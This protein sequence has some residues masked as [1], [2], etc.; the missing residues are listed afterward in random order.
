MSEHVFSKAD[1]I[2]RL[3]FC[4]KKTLGEI[5]NK[6]I[7]K[8]LQKF[9]HQ[10]GVAG[11]IIEQCVFGYNPDCEQKPDLIIIDVGVRIKTELKTTGLILEKK[12]K[13]HYVAKEPMSITAVG[14]YDISNQSFETSHFFAKLENL[15]LVYYHYLP[16]SSVN[17]S[18]YRIF[19]VVG[20]EFHKFSDEDIAVLKKD[21]ENVYALC[22]EV[23]SRHPGIKDKIWRDEVKE[24]YINVHGRLRNILSFIDLAPKFPPR[25]RLKKPVV[26]AIVANHFHYNL[27]QLPGRYSSILDVDTKCDE[28]TRE[29]KGFKISKLA[30]ILGVSYNPDTVSKAISEQIVIA[31]FGG[32]SRKLNQVELFVKLGLIA[33]TV[34]LSNKGGKTE[35][36]KLYHIDFDEMVSTTI[37]D[38]ELGRRE[39][40]FEDSEMYSYFA[41]HE[42]LC[43]IFREPKPVYR[44]DAEGNRENVNSLLDN[45]FV[46]FKR[47]VFDDAF[48][49]TYVRPVWLDTRDKIM[50]GKLKD[51]VSRK[52]TGEIIYTKKSHEISSA[53]NFLKSSENALFFR[54]GGTDSSTRYK[55]ECVNGIKMLPQYLWIKGTVIVDLLG[56]GLKKKAK[57]ISKNRLPV[58]AEGEDISSLE[59][60]AEDDSHED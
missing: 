28:I 37:D 25:F 47:L 29:Y 18:E 46:G 16:G 33:K 27:E 30:N 2:R 58:Y 55:T 57:S 23:L 42:F 17:V 3:D 20:F 32:S 5:D 15:L 14:I 44:I 22:M 12:P 49:D 40:V 48:I 10:K 7:F 19:P 35:D 31:M 11:T 52:K 56:F 21:W 51:V 53:P 45:E 38:E 8:S 26:S 13:I 36:T 34:T 39:F 54:G 1:V 4:L 24:D 50:N 43:I 41:D 60:V 6:D 59:Y 9:K